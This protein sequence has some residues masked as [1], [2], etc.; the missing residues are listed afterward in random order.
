MI[1]CPDEA[2]ANQLRVLRAHGWLRNVDPGTYDLSGYDVDP[3]YAFVNW[4]FNVRPTEL[5]A[6]FGLH[7]LKKVPTFT[8]RREHLAAQFF[9]FMDTTPWLT[10]PEV[11]P[12][13][14]PS[15]FALP[16]MVHRDATFSRADLTAYLEAEGVETRPIVT[17]NVTRHPVAELFPETFAGDF[18]GG[19]AVHTQGFYLGLSPM[20][21]DGD[22]DR[23]L[24]CFAAF[25]QRYE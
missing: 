22:M 5:Q 11:H 10:R 13:A 14:W 3:R 23:L 4:G 20:Q 25:L 6:G 17:G 2:T 18:P 16:V 9:A 15:W 21:A 7:Q 1:S 19:D 24:T 12:L 8:Q